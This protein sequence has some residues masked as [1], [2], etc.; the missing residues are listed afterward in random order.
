[1]QI[2]NEFVVSAPPSEVWTFLLDV[3]RV[4]PCMP[5][6]ELA[7]A[8]DDTTWKGRVNVTLGPVWMSFAGTV[9]LEERND[10]AH[11]VRLVAQGMEQRGKGAANA[12]IESWL[13]PGARGTTVKMRADVTLTGAAAQL[14]R[15]LL[16]E[17]SKT[18]TRQFAECLAA[19][20]ETGPDAGSEVR[21]DR[22]PMIDRR[23]VQGFR[24]ALGAIWSVVVRWVRRLFGVR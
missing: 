21:P 18:L 13:E 9:R 17:V 2:E 19:S 20:L 11:R 3:Q 14:S 12:S 4:A 16:P 6:A 7:E 1:V 15:G 22:G 5:G 23:P 8:V 10:A 24:L